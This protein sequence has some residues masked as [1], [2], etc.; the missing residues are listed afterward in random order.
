MIHLIQQ[1]WHVALLTLVAI[2]SLICGFGFGLVVLGKSEDEAMNRSLSER[3]T[4]T[5]GATLSKK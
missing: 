4:K 2:G 5:Y 3:D 1:H